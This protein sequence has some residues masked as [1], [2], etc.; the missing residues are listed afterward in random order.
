MQARVFQAVGEL[1]AT[2]V[3]NIVKQHLDS[4][5]ERVR[6]WAAWAGTLVYAE[7]PAL[8]ALQGVAEGGG[9]FAEDAARL[10]ARRLPPAQAERWRRQLAEKPARLRAA[11]A[12]ASAAGLPDAIPWLIDLMR[13]PPLV[14]RAGE[15]FSLLTGVHIGYDK[16]EGPKPEG[17]EAGPTENPEDENV[18]PDPDDNLAW[19]DAQRVAAWWAANQSRFTNGARY[20]LG[21]PISPETLQQALA[22]GYQRQRSAAALELVSVKPRHSAVRSARPRSSPAGVA[23]G[24]VTGR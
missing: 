3:R 6:F 15:A 19:P 11:V 1:G 18:A 10:A 4:A 23:G 5:D 22:V 17:F 12:A 2:D 24:E 21:K 20:L 7:A 13:Q 9:R 14:R 16:L 8:A